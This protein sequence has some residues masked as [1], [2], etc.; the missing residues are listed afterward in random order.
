MAEFRKLAKDIYAFLQRG[1][2]DKPREASGVYLMVR[3][4]VMCIDKHNLT[5]EKAIQ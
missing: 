1:F 3:R 4:R 5:K 2:P